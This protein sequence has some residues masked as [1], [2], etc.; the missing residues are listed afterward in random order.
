MDVKPS[1]LTK[2]STDYS[3]RERYHQSEKSHIETP[4]QLVGCES[5]W[6]IQ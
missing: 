5:D 4:S 1:Q 6:D 2:E 3:G